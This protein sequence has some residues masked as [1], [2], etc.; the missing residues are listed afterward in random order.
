MSSPRGALPPETVAAFLV[1]LATA[2]AE[3]VLDEAIVTPLDEQGYP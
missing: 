3:L 2:P 1:W